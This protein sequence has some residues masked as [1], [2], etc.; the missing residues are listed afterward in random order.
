MLEILKRFA[1]SIQ[2][3]SGVIESGRMKSTGGHDH[4]T[5]IGDDRTPKQKSA[6]KAKRKPR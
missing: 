2:V 6:D 4:R 1:H 3:P 5:N